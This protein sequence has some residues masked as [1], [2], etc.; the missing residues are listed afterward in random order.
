MERCS[1]SDKTHS[2]V[3]FWLAFYVRIVDI[4]IEFNICRKFRT[5][6]VSGSPF[7]LPAVGLKRFI[8]TLS[9]VCEEIVPWFQA[10]CPDEFSNVKPLGMSVF[11]SLWIDHTFSFI[12]NHMEMLTLLCL[13]QPDQSKL[14]RNVFI[15]ILEIIKKWMMNEHIFEK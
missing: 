15:R 10:K 5:H 4:V 12:V 11:S 13:D 8:R 6:L 2:I 1:L 3:P 7:L 14:E 9:D